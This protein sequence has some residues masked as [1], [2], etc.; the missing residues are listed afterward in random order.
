MKKNKETALHVKY[1]ILGGG[2]TG[3]STAYHLEKAH[4]TDYL[5]VEKNNFLGGLCASEHIQ[6]F[7]FDFAG[8]LLH[9]HHPYTKNLVR[10]LL[11]DNI[12]KIQRQ[13][14]I[15][16]S[17][18]NIP[19]PFQANL[20]A[21]PTDVRQEC[22]DGALQAAQ[23]LHRQ[24]ANFE[25]WCLQAFGAGIYKHFLR[26]YNR[27]LWQTP[28]TQLTWD[29][30]GNFVPT[31]SIKQIQ[32]SAQ[33][34]PKKSLGYNASFYYPKQGGCEALIE[35]LAAHVPNIWTRAAVQKIDLRRRC[36]RING[37]QI[38]FEYVINTLPLKNFISLCDA[39]PLGVQKAARGLKH[40]TVHVFNFAINRKVKPFHWIYFPQEDIPF[41]RVGMQ[42]SFSKQNAP[43]GCSSFYA[44]TAQPI[45][46]F[47]QAQKA[48]LNKLLQKGIIKRQDKI[49]VSFWRTL[50][51][52]YAIYNK[53]RARAVNHILRWLKQLHC[54]SAGRYGLWEYSFMER[55][56]LQGREIAKQCKDHLL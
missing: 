38:S 6:G 10:G 3:L 14:F 54:A 35:A 34:P 15:N 47:K 41:Y 37:R 9:L 40:T 53:P 13:A 24:P 2:I 23:I 39:V 31:P 5:V 55:S 27:K 42:S 11:K 36:A 32:H 28:L 25:Q 8:H 20:W 43:S 18:R 17:G 19:F 7:T 50:P 51:V 22:R 12:Q 1:L 45:T 29:W 30:C 26:P 4:Q 16:V 48:I 56:L 44:E 33:K 52:A 21:L 49:L 46:H